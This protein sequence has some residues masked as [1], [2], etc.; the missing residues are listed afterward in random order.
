MF[1]YPEHIAS[2]MDQLFK[3]LALAAFKPG[4]STADFLDAAAQFLADHNAIH[5]FREGNG[6]SQLSL[7]YLL[8]QRAGHPLD[9]TRIDRNTFMPAMIASFAGDNGPLK[10]EL[11][12]L[13]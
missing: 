6:R 5:L 2:S 12:S 13:L 10:N 8:G 4:T 11:Q 3:K 1:C 7:M 9:L